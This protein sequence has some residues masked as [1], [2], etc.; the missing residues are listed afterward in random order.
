[1]TQ[2]PLSR[3]HFVGIMAG[4]LTA[5]WITGARRLQV[6]GIETGSLSGTLSAAQRRDLDGLTALIIPTD[7]DPGAREA[8]IVDF[9]DR[10]LT[11]FAQDQR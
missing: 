3:R 10:G 1:M 6:S 9:I 8:R 7:E 11:S 4:A 5:T 2:D